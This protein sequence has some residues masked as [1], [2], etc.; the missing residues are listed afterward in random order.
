M[1]VR[2]CGFDS[3]LAH[4][5]ASRDA[6]RYPEQLLVIFD[7]E[8]LEKFMWH[9]YILKCCDDSYYVG[10]TEDLKSRLTDHNRGK[11]SL[12]TKVRRPVR[13]IYFEELEGKNEVERRE[14]ELKKLS[15][16]NKERLIK[17]G[18]DRR[19]SLVSDN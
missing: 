1:A 4:M 17:Y 18:K 2:P 11:G 14:I 7:C 10:I 19:V 3:H 9:A 6:D 5:S 12:Y 8:G 16:K 13:L 15:R